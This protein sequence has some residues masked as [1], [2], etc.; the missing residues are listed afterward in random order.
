MFGTLVCSDHCA[1]TQDAPFGP[2][3]A[4]SVGTPRPGDAQEG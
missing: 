1:H 4:A 2:D 3:S